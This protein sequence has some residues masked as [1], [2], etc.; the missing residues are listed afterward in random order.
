MGTMFEQDD[1]LSEL[2]FVLDASKAI[3]PNDQ[4]A[5][6]LSNQRNPTAAAHIDDQR[7]YSTQPTA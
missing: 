2:G 4:A 7:N 1:S 3:A 6:R 5:N